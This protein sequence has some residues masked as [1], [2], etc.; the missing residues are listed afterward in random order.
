MA[1]CLLHHHLLHHSCR[2]EYLEALIATVLLCYL[3]LQPQT[4]SSPEQFNS[5][6]LRPS[7]AHIAESPPRKY[8]VAIMTRSPAVLGLLLVLISPLLVFAQFGHFF[9]NMFSGGGGGGGGGGQRGR[10]GNVASD[11]EWYR[12]TYDGGLCSRLEMWSFQLMLDG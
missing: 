7:H 5:F 6:I 12:R 3:D 10:G 2:L 9:E 11:S 8:L 4:H 1:V